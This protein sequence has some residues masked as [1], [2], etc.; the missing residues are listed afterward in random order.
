MLLFSPHYP[1]YLAWLVPLLTLVPDIAVL[2]Y[3]CGFFYMCTTAGA[4]G[5]GPEQFLLNQIL[6]AG[7]L[8]A[9][10]L[11][12]ALRRWPI[13]RLN[14]SSPASETIPS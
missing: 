12:I 6:Y 9:F 5:Y 8:I 10:L 3:V 14:L 4:V 2:A 11:D 1:W 7:I 13:V